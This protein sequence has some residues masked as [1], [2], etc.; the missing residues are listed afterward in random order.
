MKRGIISQF[1]V[2]FDE[3]FSLFLTNIALTFIDL[4]K[5]QSIIVS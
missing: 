2:N 4:P 5:N 1:F 3:K